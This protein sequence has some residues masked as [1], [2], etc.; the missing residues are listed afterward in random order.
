MRKNILVFV[1]IVF[2]L[3]GCSFKENDD[4]SC[5]DIIKDAIN[6]T[7]EKKEAINTK[8]V[9]KNIS[10]DW[11]IVEAPTNMSRTAIP[12]SVNEETIETEWTAMFITACNKKNNK[13]K[14]LRLFKDEEDKLYVG[15]EMDA[16][17]VEENIND[18]TEN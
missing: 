4:D 9:Q 16:L 5:L 13:C 11:I 2:L 14:D 15:S 18:N 7:Y 1:T 3:V 17:L 6:K 12:D 10:G 8:N